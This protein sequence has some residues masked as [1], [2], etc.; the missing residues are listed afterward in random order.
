MRTV[1]LIAF[2]LFIA[3]VTAQRKRPPHGVAPCGPNE[4]YSEC[5]S[6]SC[7]EATCARPVVGPIC[8][9]DCTKGCFCRKGFFRSVRRICVPRKPVPVGA[10]SM[11]SSPPSPTSRLEHHVDH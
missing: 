7:K 2:A 8:T 4:E 10:T 3:V 6:S 11:S 5:K 1:A 9:A